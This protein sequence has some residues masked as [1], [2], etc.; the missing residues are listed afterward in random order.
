MLPRFLATLM[1][2]LLAGCQPAPADPAPPEPVAAP[3]AAQAASPQALEAQAWPRPLFC[4]P[5]QPLPSPPPFCTRSIGA[6]DC[7][8]SPPLAVPALRGLADGRQTLTEQ[9]AARRAQ[10]WP[11]VL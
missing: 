1:L 3:M 9:Q 2:L 5:L 4:A 7:W 6:V 8:R 10:C 11:G